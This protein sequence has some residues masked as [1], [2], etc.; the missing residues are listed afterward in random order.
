MGKLAWRNLLRN[1]R[2][3]AL[4][5]GSVATA[6]LLLSLLLSILA[7]MERAEGS[8]DNRLVV[9]H[10]ISLTFDLPE[11]YWQKLQP[12]QH[13]Q[14]LTPLDWFGGIYKDDRPQNFFAQFAC[15]PATFRAVWPEFRFA[16]QEYAT[17]A[18]ERTACVAGA[19]LATK[20]G[21]K[22][23]DRIV[24]QGTIYPADLELV[25]RGIYTE[26]SAPAAEKQI[27]FHRQYLQESLGNPGTVGTFWLRLDSPQSIPAVVQTAE[28][29]FVNSSAPVRVETEKAF[30]LSFLEMLGNIRMLFGAIG[31]AVIV[32]ILFMVANTLAM[33]A[34]ERTRE[35]AILKTLGFRRPALMALVI[36]ESMAVG[37]SG[38]V[39]SLLL[40]VGLLGGLGR[41]LE[42]FFP[43]FGTVR[44]TPAVGA[45]VLALGAAIGLLTGGFPAYEVSRLR[46]AEG[47]RRLV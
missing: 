13:V 23:G 1:K 3:T 7:A 9:R 8:A 37:L 41:F 24:L 35:V 26:P 19:A 11:A 2:R 28:A 12:L 30:Q 15:D 43:V 6:L 22:I 39:L 38:A 42:D 47:L 46:I 20:H 32:S 10:A 4:T 14:A 44:L 45:A 5:I 21:W 33:A 17:F 29:L 27:L 40:A 31:L 18:A 36:S 34:R 25:L 16:A